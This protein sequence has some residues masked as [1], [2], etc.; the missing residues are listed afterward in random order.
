MAS[1][2]NLKKYVKSLTEKLKDE[3]LLYLALHPDIEPAGF[4][5]IIREIDQM[6]MELIYKLNHTKYRPVELSAQKFVNQSISDTEKKL[7]Q[8]L[9][10]MHDMAK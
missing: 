4:V 7:G 2:K 5:I 1:I 10:K 3:C 9:E 6:E 8:L